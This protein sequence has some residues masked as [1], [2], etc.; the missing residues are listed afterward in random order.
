MQILFHGL[1]EEQRTKTKEGMNVDGF[2][3]LTKAALL[4]V[5]FF[6]PHSNKLD[7]K[8][9]R[10]S[11]YKSSQMKES[12]WPFKLA[13]SIKFQN[14]FKIILFKNSQRSSNT[15]YSSGGIAI[16]LFKN[17]KVESNFSKVWKNYEIFFVVL[18][19]GS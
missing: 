3:Y 13:L 6:I 15:T 1:A 4:Q 14:H 8:L 2:P 9:S 7:V 12:L 5:Y 17:T 11:K 19:C 18:G 16:W 10:T